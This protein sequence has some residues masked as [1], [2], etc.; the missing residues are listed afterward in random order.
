V[1]GDKLT[2]STKSELNAP[3]QERP[4]W[5]PFVI[6]CVQLSEESA[7]GVFSGN[8]VLNRAQ[9]WDRSLVRLRVLGILERVEK[10]TRNAHTAAYRMANQNDAKEALTE[11]G[12]E[13]DVR[14]P[15]DFFNLSNRKAS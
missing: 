1:R 7:D 2:A 8:S 6:A 14:L 10:G 9:R 5:I 15:G 11:I 4:D 3:L 13:P 12:Q